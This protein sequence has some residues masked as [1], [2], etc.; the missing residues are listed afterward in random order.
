MLVEFASIFQIIIFCN[1]V[2]YFHSNMWNIL[3]FKE[4]DNWFVSFEGSLVPIQD[5]HLF[6]DLKFFDFCGQ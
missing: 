3:D 2:K 4:Y 6:L 1:D 5:L